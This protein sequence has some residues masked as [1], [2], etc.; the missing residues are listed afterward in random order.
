[1][2]MMPEVMELECEGLVGM[3]EELIMCGREGEVEGKVMMLY[4]W[5]GEV[6]GKIA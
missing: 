1:M 3:A 2:E 4:G 5:L 6:N